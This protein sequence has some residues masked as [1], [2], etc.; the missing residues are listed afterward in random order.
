[1]VIMPGEALVVNLARPAHALR[2]P[3]P[4][5]VVRDPRQPH[6]VRA[7]TISRSLPTRARW[8]KPSTC[9]APAGRCGLSSP[10]RGP[11]SRGRPA[12][13]QRNRSSQGRYMPT[14]RGDDAAR[15]TCPPK[16][17]PCRSTARGELLRAWPSHAQ[18]LGPASEDVARKGPRFCVGR[19]APD[20]PEMLAASLRGTRRPLRAPC[21]RFQRPRGPRSAHPAHHPAHRSSPVRRTN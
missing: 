5:T 20:S 9:A 4:G 11:L 1:V 13:S 10:D 15:T 12:T 19:S 7:R 14:A 2:A 16:G 18:L 6:P 3:V 17:F 8:G 21:R